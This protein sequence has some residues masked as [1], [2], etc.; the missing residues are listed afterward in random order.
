MFL[1]HEGTIAQ[2]FVRC[3]YLMEQLNYLTYDFATIRMNWESLWVDSGRERL[4][5]IFLALL[6]LRELFVQC[7]RI[8]PFQ[9]IDVVKLLIDFLILSLNLL[10]GSLQHLDTRLDSLHGL[11]N[12]V[13]VTGR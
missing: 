4:L 7:L 3:I 9:F 8:D 12:N 1:C 5:E 2:T 6:Q 10:Q 13:H 11:D